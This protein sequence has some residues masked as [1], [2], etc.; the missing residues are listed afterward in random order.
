MVASPVVLTA[1][2]RASKVARRFW[3]TFGSTCGV[4][5]GSTASATILYRAW[6]R[7]GTTPLDTHSDALIHLVYIR[8]MQFG[9]LNNT[10]LLGAPF[11]QHLLDFPTGNELTHL[12]LWRLVSLFTSNPFTVL[13]VSFLLGFGIVAVSAELVARQLGIDRWRAALIGIAFALLPYHFWQGAQHPFLAS[14]WA[15]PLGIL[16][17]VWT[18]DGDL[19]IPWLTGRGPTWWRANRGRFAVLVTCVVI[20]SSS[21]SYYTMMTSALLVGAAAGGQLRRRSLRD[22]AAAACALAATGLVFLATMTQALLWRRS[23]GVNPWVANRPIAD[24]EQWSMHLSQLVLPGPEHRITALADLG[25][26][27]RNV[28]LPGEPG[29]YAG[30]LGVVGACVA[31]ATLLRRGV[32]G[33]SR[34][35]L[36]VDM[37]LLTLIAIA[38]ATVGGLSGIAAAIGF[39][40]IRVWARMSPYLSLFGLVTLGALP[41]TAGWRARF[42][43]PQVRWLAG[44][45][46]VL[47]VLVDQTPATFPPDLSSTEAELA[48]N[49]RLVAQLDETLPRHAAIFQLPVISFP[50]AGFANGL[51]GFKLLVPT[52]VDDGN[53][54]WS[55]GGARGRESDWQLNWGQQDPRTMVTGLALAGFDAVTVERVG[56]VDGAAGLRAELAP[57]LGRPRTPSAGLE[58]YDL[59]PLR[60]KLAA[61][62]TPAALARARRLLL[63]SAVARIENSEPAIAPPQPQR[64]QWFEQRSAIVV[65]NPLPGSRRVQLTLTLSARARS[66]V[67]I[68]GP[69]IHRSLSVSTTPRTFTLPVTLPPG[70]VRFSVST[71][72]PIDLDAPIILQELASSATVRVDRIEVVD[73]SVVA[74]ARS[75]DE[76]G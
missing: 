75:V 60:K 47:L 48:A 8:N 74:I 21:G 58:W 44:V 39:T 33:G 45:V 53:F 73:P 30:L 61:H 38:W 35:R 13:N 29:M 55:F 37:G 16:V 17:A 6:G 22:L 52:L 76:K 12:V 49:R 72:A 51:D 36:V 25:S 32:L 66:T 57:L 2:G 9:D 27:V 5:V 4:F 23:H 28:T 56:Y 68:S 11:G 1:T 43:R 19:P 31:V 71:D 41:L 15:V 59:R 42:S 63:Y 40:Q 7:L 24:V 20:G 50:E 3:A 69:G 18:L 10:P 65:H 54:R 70:D 46:V 67:D 14:Y 64:A 34:R 26:R 62:V